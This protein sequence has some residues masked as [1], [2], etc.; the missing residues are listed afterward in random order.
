VRRSLALVLAA[1]AL[2]S[3]GCASGGGKA[4]ISILTS[5]SDEAIWEA[6]EKATAK[7]DYEAAR[8]YFKRIIDGFPQSEY[9]PSARIATA[10]SYFFQE[11]AAN[12]VLAISQYR[13]FVTL[14]PQHPKSDY[15]QFQIAEAYFKQR[16]GPDRDPTPTMHALEEYNR[17]LDLYPSS[18]YVE[19]ARPRITA[20]RQGLARGDFLVGY[21]YQRTRKVYRAAVKRYEDVLD[22]YPDY[23]GADEV[24]YRLSQ[25]LVYMARSAEA[26]PRLQQ[27]RDTYPSSPWVDDANRLITEIA[28]KHSAPALPPATLPPSPA[29]SPAAEQPSPSPA[30]AGSGAT[31]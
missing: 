27:L 13:D 31:P 2:T 10:D 25:C 4:D 14:F 16:N 7:H 19:K 20:T 30:P 23:E 8:Q 11:G 17:L 29:A 3:Y 24:L 26:L 28:E 22:Q 6:G 1:A 15:A 18:P 5:S 9:G 21:F 12:Y